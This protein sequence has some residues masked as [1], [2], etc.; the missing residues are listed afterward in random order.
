MKKTKVIT[1][2]SDKYLSDNDGNRFYNPSRTITVAGNAIEIL[3]Q[4]NKS[5]G[6]GIIKVDK[7]HYIDLSDP[8]VGLRCPD[9]FINIDKNRVL[10]DGF[11]YDKKRYKEGVKEKNNNELRKTFKRLRNLINTNITSPE[12]CLWVTLTYAD[13]VKGKEGNEQLYKDFK[14]GIQ[15]LRRKYGHFEYISVVEPQAR[16]A[17]HCHCIFIFEKKTY[18][19]N[20]EIQTAWGQ[21]FTKTKKMRTDVDN[22]GSYL[23]AYL[24]DIPLDDVKDSHCY[25]MQDAEY[26]VEHIV[27]KEGKKYIKGGRIPLYPVGMKIYRTSRGIKQPEIIKDADYEQVKEIIGTLPC[28][29]ETTNEILLDEEDSNYRNILRYR[30]YNKNIKNQYQLRMRD[31]RIRANKNK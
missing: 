23:T 31:E 1:K 12:C 17:W 3:E 13:N 6:P 15:R 5:V 29:Y 28:I 11:L 24:T 14:N 8:A 26:L 19:P 21:G 27:E 30:Q 16:G 20:K 22:L 2:Q 25:S 18:I 4:S 10:R 9:D 7:Y